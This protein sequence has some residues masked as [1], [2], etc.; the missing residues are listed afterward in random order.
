[1]D[2]ETGRPLDL[3]TGR[4]AATLA[5]RLREHP[6]AEIISR[7]RAGSYPDGART[8]APNAV[9]VADRFHLWQNLGT[10]V[11]AG[12]RLH[13]T[14]LK[15]AAA[16]PDGPTNDGDSVDATKAMSPIEARI[17]ERHAT[18][19]ALPAQEHGIREIA[20]EPHIGGHRPPQ[21]PRGSPRTAADRSAPAPAEPARPLQALPGQT[22]GRRTHQRDP[23]A[24]PTPSPRLSRELPDHQ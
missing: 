17:R 24:C 10:A 13:G 22:L 11:E 9:Q 4:D 1:M 14:C 23:A 15:T 12:I 2:C 19:R 5:G 20:R 6:G 16:S 7:Y 21:C 8:S 3:L 18:I